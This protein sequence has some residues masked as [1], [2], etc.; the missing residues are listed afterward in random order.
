MRSRR[1]LRL[2]LSV[3]CL[4]VAAP[5]PAARAACAG[6]REPVRAGD[7][8]RARHAVRCLV[9]Q[10]RA[11]RGLPRLDGNRRLHRAAAAQARDMVARHYFGHTSPAGTTVVTR[12]SAYL[13]GAPTWALG[14]VLGWGAGSPG[15]PAGVVRQWL[16]SPPHAALLLSRAYR[17][18]GVGVAART[19]WSAAAGGATYAVDLG[20]RR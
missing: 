7:A 13:R 11:A 3:P 8:A 16:D 12:A 10:A 14:E 1:A 20:V 4:M 18:V 9:D 5:A 2:L 19:P 17:D 6:A 15:T